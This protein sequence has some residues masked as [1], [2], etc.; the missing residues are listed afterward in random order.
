[1]RTRVIITVSGALAVVREALILSHPLSR[2]SRL[3]KSSLGKSFPQPYNPYPPGILRADLRQETVGVRREVQGVFLK[4]LDEWHLLFLRPR[5]RR[6]SG[7]PKGRHGNWLTTT[8]PSSSGPPTTL[9]DRTIISGAGTCN[10]KG[11]IHVQKTSVRSDCHDG[12]R[13]H[14]SHFNRTESS[15]ARTNTG[16]C[17]PDTNRPALLSAEMSAVGWK[18]PN[19]PAQHGAHSPL[20]LNLSPSFALTCRLGSGLSNLF[21]KAYNAP[22]ARPNTG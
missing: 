14:E 6:A 13:T 12:S 10:Q 7:S 17:V 11:E 5:K 16:V 20:C 22:F 2:S 15:G 19:A 4:A 18:T 1:M 21:P 3:R 8:W 9:V